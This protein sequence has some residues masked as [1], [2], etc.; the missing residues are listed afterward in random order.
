MAKSCWLIY[1]LSRIDSV[2]T[3]RICVCACQKLLTT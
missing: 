2:V 1:I 3:L